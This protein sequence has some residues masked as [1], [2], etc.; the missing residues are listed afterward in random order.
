MWPVFLGLGSNLGDRYASLMRA[1]ELLHGAVAIVAISP[2]YETAPWGDVDQPAFLNLCIAGTTTLQPLELLAAIKRIE[3]DMGREPTRR[4]GPRV[5]D[6]DVLLY[7]RLILHEPELSIPHVSMPARAFVLA[8][9]ADLIPD[10]VHPQLGKSIHE[11]LAAVDRSG[12]ERY[13]HVA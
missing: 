3:H 12:V 1:A 9:L 8:P 2:I 7:D 5:I 10:F 13:R 4:W 6:I 11:L